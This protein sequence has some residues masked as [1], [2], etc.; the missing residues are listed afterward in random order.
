[1]TVLAP[2]LQAFFT[3]RLVGQRQASPNTVSAY[4]DAFTQLLTYVAENKGKSPVQLDFD[5]LDAETI[6]GFLTHLERDRGVSVATRNARLAAVRSMFGFAAYRHPEHAALIARV[7]AIPAKRGERAL[8][9]FLSR[10][11]MDA[12]LIAP[13]RTCWTGRRDHT[14]LTVDIQTGLRV[15]ASMHRPDS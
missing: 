1:M 13:D 11:E 4:R 2:T 3:D 14:L 7:L 5:D 15:S 8:V 6:G 12:L 10:P 9:T